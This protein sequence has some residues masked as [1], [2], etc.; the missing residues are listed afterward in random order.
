MAV[1]RV[2]FQ[3]R[4]DHADLVEHG[5][6]VTQGDE[7]SWC[8]TF[9]GNFAPKP[10]LGWPKPGYALHMDEVHLLINGDPDNLWCVLDQHGTVLDILQPTS[11]YR[12][13]PV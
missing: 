4:R 3:A 1:S 8:L 5:L 10:S 12:Y 2:S 6:A 7:P 9:S 13:G 11:L